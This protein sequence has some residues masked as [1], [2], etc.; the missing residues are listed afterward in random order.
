MIWWI[1]KWI[2]DQ[3]RLWKNLNN[4]TTGKNKTTTNTYLPQLMLFIMKKYFNLRGRTVSLLYHHHLS[5]NA[6]HAQRQLPGGWEMGGTTPYKAL[7]FK[8][9]S[10]DHLHYSYFGCWFKIWFMELRILPKYAPTW[11]QALTYIPRWPAASTP[12][13]P[14]KSC[15]QFQQ[16]YVYLL[17]VNITEARDKVMRGNRKERESIS[18]LIQDLIF[19]FFPQP[20]HNIGYLISSQ[21]EL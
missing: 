13:P 14:D 21:Q 19:L 15:P 6:G 11:P 18:L 9:G 12:V 20:T 7:F 10:W 8:M 2:I 16:M 17:R 1:Q 3:K 4:S 5:P